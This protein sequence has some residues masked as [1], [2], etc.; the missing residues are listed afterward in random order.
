MQVD[1]VSY[2]ATIN[3]IT[4][5]ILGYNNNNNATLQCIAQAYQIYQFHK[6]ANYEDIPIP[7]QRLHHKL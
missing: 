5:I 2:V 4:G 3:R 7:L 6:L 1:I